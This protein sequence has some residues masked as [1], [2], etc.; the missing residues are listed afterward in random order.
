M[1]RIVEYPG[2]G[3]AFH[4]GA[5][6]QDERLVGELAYDRQ[7]VADQDVGDARFVADVGEQVEHVGLGRHVQCGNGLVEDQDDGLGR[8]G[9]R[10]C[11]PL[12]LAARERAGQRPGL[13]RIQAHQA[14]ELGNP[15]AATVGGPAMV[16]AQHLVDGG[17]GALARVQAGVRVLEYDLHLAAPAS[18]V[19][20]GP[21]RP[22]PVV[23]AG[24]DGPACGPFQADDHPRDRGLPRARLPDDSQRPAG[25][26]T[27]RD[28]VDGDEIAEFLA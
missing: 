23:P 13:P 4:H 20:G 16:Q 11:D 8:E 17:F 18:A 14:G 22:G 3:P 9:A 6:V 19:P 7:V 5:A 25:P 24:G 2:G 10:D 27:E 21:G 12:P 28:I 26:E 1:L 15:G